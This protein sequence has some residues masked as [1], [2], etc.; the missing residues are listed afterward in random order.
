MNYGKLDR[1]IEL[2]MMM[3]RIYWCGLVQGALIALGAM[4]TAY[5]IWRWL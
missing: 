3:R 4:L 5:S 2:V 1:E